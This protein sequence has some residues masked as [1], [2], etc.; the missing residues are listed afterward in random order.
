MQ[1][2]DFPPTLSGV[3]VLCLQG[4]WPYGENNHSFSEK[5]HCISHCIC[6][7]SHT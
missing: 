1:A 7:L 4:F 3:Y 2:V 6:N 5:D